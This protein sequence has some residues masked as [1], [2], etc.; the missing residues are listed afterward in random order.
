M[1]DTTIKSEVKT[2]SNDGTVPMITKDSIGNV[3]SKIDEETNSATNQKTVA[4][5]TEETNGNL[6]NQVKEETA[7][8]NEAQNTTDEYLYTKT[9]EY[10]SEMFKVVVQNIPSKVTY[11][12]CRQ[13]IK[14]IVGFLPKKLKFN[15]NNNYAFVNFQDEEQRLKAMETLNGYEWKGKTFLC[16]KAGPA[17]D[18]FIRENKRRANDSDYKSKKQ[19]LEEIPGDTPEEKILHVVCPY[20]KYEYEEQVKLKEQEMKSYVQRLTENMRRAGVG[21]K[22]INERDDKMCLEMLPIITSPVQTNYRNKVELTIGFGSDGKDNAVG[23]RLGSYRDGNLSIVRPTKCIN[24]TQKSIDVSKELETFL[25]SQSYP[26]FNLTNHQG[27]WQQCTVRTC[28][29]DDV[30]VIIQINASHIN[31]TNSS[32]DDKMEELKKKLIEYFSSEERIVKVTS[33]YLSWSTQKNN[34][35]DTFVHLHG[36]Q[37]I[38]ETLNGLKFRIS[39]DAFFQ[40]NT[41]GAE[42]LYSRVKD[43]CDKDQEDSCVLDVCCGTGTIGLFIAKDSDIPVVGIEISEQAVEDAKHNAT[44]NGVE[45]NKFVCGPAEKVL[46]KEIRALN[47]KNVIAVVDPPRAG[48]HK[49]VLHLLRSCEAI[50]KIVYVSCSPKQAADNFIGLCRPESKKYRGKPFQTIRAV[51]VDLFPQTPHCE[52]IVQLERVSEST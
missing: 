47:K 28:S 24:C 22:W 32:E 2:E 10:T 46:S 34:N 25:Q 12:Q 9:G 1:E 51:P 19:K 16:K 36:E 23:F 21:R 31:E 6:T 8:T 29:T 33:L 48:L 11:G 35:I 26:S 30:M 27:L 4:M 15:S 42:L 50:Q 39:P 20:A 43:W 40:V 52:L 18:P 7:S 41:P 38:H 45:N 14:E 37:H 3:D 49:D 5:E 13:K 44:L 17:K